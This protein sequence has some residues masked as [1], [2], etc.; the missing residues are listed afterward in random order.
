[1]ATD[2]WIEYLNESLSDAAPQRPGDWPD[3]RTLTDTSNQTGPTDATTLQVNTQEWSSPSEA[4]QVS[5]WERVQNSSLARKRVGH[6]PTIAEP[7]NF[8]LR[9]AERPHLPVDAAKDDRNKDS[10]RVWFERHQSPSAGSLTKI[11]L[12]VK[13]G[14]PN[15]DSC[16][17]LAFDPPV[18]ESASHGWKKVSEP[19][20][21]SRRCTGRCIRAGRKNPL[22]CRDKLW[23]L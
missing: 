2:G 8:M 16:Y 9:Q 18:N 11:T 17:P 4:Y 22:R 5:D 21:W 3:A 14:S 19:R 15:P 1:M 10:L 13:P 23:S 6:R 20:R 12:K 7:S